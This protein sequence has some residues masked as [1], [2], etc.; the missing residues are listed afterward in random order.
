MLNLFRFWPII[1]FSEAKRR[2]CQESM[3][4]VRIPT[5]AGEKLGNPG[6]GSSPRAVFKSG[7]LSERAI[8]ISAIPE[9]TQECSS[10]TSLMTTWDG[11]KATA[12][13]FSLHFVR[14][15]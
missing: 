3:A 4:S 2:F 9:P 15:L 5:E 1:H 7:Y 12:R 10:P 14:L 8:V 6:S 11:F 13:P